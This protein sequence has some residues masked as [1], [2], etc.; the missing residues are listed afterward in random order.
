MGD[1]EP[2]QKEIYS[3]K[4]WRKKRK[5]TLREM[6]LKLDM[7]GPSYN[8]YEKNHTEPGIRLARRI[9]EALGVDIDQISTWNFPP[10]TKIPGDDEI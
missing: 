3:L 6:G 9:A 2:E 10:R 1:G 7:K 5:M 8:D 4:K